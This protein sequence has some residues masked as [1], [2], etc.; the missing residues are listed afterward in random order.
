MSNNKI[1]SVIIPNYNGEKYIKRCI[2]SLTKQDK[3]RLEIIFVD[4]G[5]KDNSVRIIEAI[6]KNFTNIKII[7]KENGGASSAR[8]VGI[9]MATGKYTLFLDVDDKLEDN[10]IDIMLDNIGNNDELVF[11]YTNYDEN[12][13]KLRD[14]NQIEAEISG[15]ELRENL[16]YYVARTHFYG[17]CNKLFRTSLLQKNN[18]KFPLGIT[19]GED[20]IFNL[21]VAEKI[22]SIKFMNLH[23]YQYYSNSSSVSHTF[24]I[25]KWKNQML[26]IKETY[27]LHPT[28]S[29]FE[30]EFIV[31]RLYAVYASYSKNLNR[32]E[33]VKILYNYWAEAYKDISLDG[34]PGKLVY[35]LPIEMAKREKFKL[36][37]RYLKCVDFA[38]LVKRFIK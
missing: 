4:D 26:M 25:N 14:R 32:K 17:P 12:A 15:D 22:G 16:F 27:N 19:T 5:S 13:N 1:I 20:Y 6:S 3:G 36:L 37:Y 38:I 29:E 9:T 24:N 28:R 7:T 21:R 10:A 35:K 11:S 33:V 8:N 18:I 2:D 31:K 34:M 23:L 30:S